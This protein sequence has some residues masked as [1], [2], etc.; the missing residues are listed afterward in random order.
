MPVKSS[1]EIDEASSGDEGSSTDEATLEFQ[2]R[3]AAVSGKMEQITALIERVSDVNAMDEQR[4][5][6]L[7]MAAANGHVEATKAL[8]EAKAD[9][10]LETSSNNTALK[11]ATKA[12]EHIKSSPNNPKF[13]NLSGV[14]NV[15]NTHAKKAKTTKNR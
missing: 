14:I 6:A 10:S 11:L 9:P 15:L 7:H 4:A 5:T 13:V 8:L 3:V 1:A 12:K 2:L